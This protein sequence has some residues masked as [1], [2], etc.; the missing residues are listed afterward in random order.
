MKIGHL[1]CYSKSA[2][3]EQHSLISKLKLFT[4]TEYTINSIIEEQLLT[5]RRWPDFD[6][7]FINKAASPT[8]VSTNLPLH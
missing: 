1:N 4:T 5:V 6:H 7:C 2:L 8:Y 3:V